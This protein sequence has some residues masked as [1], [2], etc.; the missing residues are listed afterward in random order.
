MA[1]W[2][3]RATDHRR[4][5]RP[6]VRGR[7]YR[8][9]PGRRRRRAACSRPGWSTPP[10]PLPVGDA[11][12][13]RSTRRCR[14]A[15]DAL[16]GVGP[17]RRA[18][19]QRRCPRWS[20]L[21]GPHR[22]HDER[23]PP[24]RVPPRRR[25]PAGREIEAARSVGLRFHPDPRLDGPGGARPAA[26]TTWSRTSTR[27]CWPPRRP[28]TVA[29]PVAGLHAPDR[30]RALLAVLVSLRPAARGG[31]ARAAGGTCCCRPL[32]RRS[33]R[34]S[35]AAE[36]FGCSPVDYMESLGWL[37]ADV[38]GRPRGAPRRRRGDED[39]GHRHRCGALPLIQRPPR[40]GHRTR[41]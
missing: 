12:T 7:P 26:S 25:G 10:P 16:P 9:R 13:G 28:S 37:G 20:G 36:R 38:P 35:S 4:R 29:R 27:C 3:S 15:H 8:R 5:S 11:P 30:R 2:W 14:L 1:T 41:P 24:L 31:G 6:G 32:R 17:H 21:A 34:R 39:R 22:L 23:R 33:T 19:R 40:V 18:R